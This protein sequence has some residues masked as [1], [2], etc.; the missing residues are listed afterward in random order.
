MNLPIYQTVSE[1]IAE[2]QPSDEVVQRWLQRKGVFTHVSKAKEYAELIPFSGYDDKADL[3]RL[4]RAEWH[5]KLH[6]RLLI[7]LAAA[8]LILAVVATIACTL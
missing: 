3:Q 7:A 2:L 1:I 5:A 4:M 8:L 6:R